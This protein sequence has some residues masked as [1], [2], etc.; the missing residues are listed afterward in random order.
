MRL[1]QGLLLASLV[2]LAACQAPAPPTP[3]AVLTTPTAVPAV[4]TPV[5]AAPSA[6]P[7]GPSAVPASP[8]AVRAVATAIPKPSA[9]T[10]A[11]PAT[12]VPP[13][14]SASRIEALNAANAAFRSGDLKT[15]AGLYERVV[16]T[17]PSQG[18]VSVASAAIDDFAHFRG[19][20]ALLADG[21]EDEGRAMLQDL[22]KRDPNAPLARLG[23]QL[24]DQYGMTGSLR[25]ACV[26]LQPQVATLAG[27]T[28]A[29]LQALGV[30]VD[31]P[32][33]CSV[34]RG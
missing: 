8:T 6:A 16:N 21:R 22:Q 17:P 29:T 23:S 7:V 5:P 27:P 4:P 20:V 11:A 15:A 3:T 18:E 12:A 10:A 2:A 26:Q 28:L 25:A 31:A 30:T 1:Q 19:M 32:T 9:S 33:L 24:Y 14:A 13:P 34:P